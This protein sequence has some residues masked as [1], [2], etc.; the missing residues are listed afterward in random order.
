MY[1]RVNSYAT[2]DSFIVVVG[3]Q[4]AFPLDLQLMSLIF[5]GRWSQPKRSGSWGV[6]VV[7][8]LDPSP[9]GPIC[10]LSPLPACRRILHNHRG[11]PSSVHLCN[12]LY[13]FLLHVKINVSRY[14]VKVTKSDIKLINKDTAEED[15]NFS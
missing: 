3:V 4:S 11:W 12:K 7:K 6:G 10:S 14:L 2:L 13:S 15:K 9:L 5:F 1:R 8:V